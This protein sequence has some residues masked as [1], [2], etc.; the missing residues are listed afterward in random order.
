MTSKT[1]TDNF[2]FTFKTFTGKLLIAIN[3]MKAIHL[4]SKEIMETYRSKRTDSM[5]PHIFSIGN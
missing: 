2:P 5:C 3:P 1:L 4:Y